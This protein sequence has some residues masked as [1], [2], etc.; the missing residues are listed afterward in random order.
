MAEDIGIV[1][2]VHDISATVILQKSGDRCGTCCSGCDTAKEGLEVEALNPI[3][4][5]VGQRVRIAFKP[6]DYMKG[7]IF[8]Y[9][10]PMLLFILGAVIGKGLGEA[11]FPQYSSDLVAATV[12]FALLL[13]SYLVLQVW[14]KKADSGHGS[15]PVIESIIDD[16]SST[17]CSLGNRDFSS[18]RARVKQ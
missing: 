5:Q 4:A 12:A 10:L 15:H 18:N 14:S 11:H 7:V 16:D 2:S 13:L 17:P 6:Y 8:V 1:K 9:G 3:G